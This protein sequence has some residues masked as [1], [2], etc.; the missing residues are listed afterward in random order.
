MKEK[1]KKMI[2]SGPW[3]QLMGQNVMDFAA[4]RPG[5]CP[6]AALHLRS[7]VPFNSLLSRVT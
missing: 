3:E 5:P 1:R 4:W 6:V 2:E 7:A